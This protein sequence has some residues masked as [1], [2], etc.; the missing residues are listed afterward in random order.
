MVAFDVFLNGKRLCTAGV[1]TDGVLTAVVDWVGHGPGKE[2]LH[3]NVFGL[4]SPTRQHAGWARRDLKPGDKIRVKIVEAN[5][6][7]KPK[8]KYV[9]DTEGA[10]LP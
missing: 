10:H 8:H 6:V 9:S 5:K 1:N 2:S 7:D 4:Y 3:V